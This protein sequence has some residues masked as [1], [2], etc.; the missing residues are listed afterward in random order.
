MTERQA[1]LPRTG[2][3]ALGVVGVERPRGRREPA[4]RG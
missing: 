3:Q 4:R 2:A 1:Q